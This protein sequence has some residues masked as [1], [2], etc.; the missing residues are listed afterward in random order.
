MWNLSWRGSFLAVSLVIFLTT[1]AFAQSE[2]S[3]VASMTC[4]TT[5]FQCK[6]DHKCIPQRWVCDGASDC[7]DESDENDETCKSVHCG[8]D[9]FQCPNNNCISSVWRCDGEPDCENGEDEVGC[10][11]TCNATTEFTC[12]DGQ[13]ISAQWKCDSHKDCSDGSDEEGCTE[14]KCGEF[15]F[16]CNNG[17][18]IQDT[19]VCDGDD[20]CH[21]MSDEQQGCIDKED[22]CRK[23]EFQC[24]TL[25]RMCIHITW[26]CDGDYDCEDQSDEKH[27]PPKTCENNTFDCLGDGTKCIPYSQVCDSRNDCGDFQDETNPDGASCPEE[28]PCNKA[29]NGGCSQLCNLAPTGVVC[30]CHPGFELRNGSHFDCD[31]IDECSI[32]GTCSQHCR[33]MKGSYKC[34]CIK[35]Y[36]LVNEHHCKALEG[37]PELFLADR[38][39]LRRYQ[40]ETKSY[41]LLVGKKDNTTVKGAIAIDFHY[42]Q[43]LLYWTDVNEEQIM[44]IDLTTEKIEMVVSE[45]VKTPDGLAVDW[46]HHHLY[47]TDTGMNHIEVATLDGSKRKVLISDDLDEPRAIA[48]DPHNAYIYWTDWGQMPKIEKCGM[49][50]K[51]RKVI[52][53]TDITWPNGL[54]IDYVDQ[55]LYWIDAK[56]HQ[57]GSSDLEGNNRK[58]ILRGHQYL[59]HP[60]AITVFEDYLYWSDWPSESV[61]RFNKF[62][63]GEVE[64]IAQGLNYPMDIHIYH[65]Y[66]QQDYKNRCGNNNGGCEQ[67]CL[68]DPTSEGFT[69]EC[70]TNFYVNPSDNT[71]CLA[72]QAPITTA[73]PTTQAPKTQAPTTAPAK[74]VTSAVPKAP[75]PNTTPKE[76][77]TTAKPVSST[78]VSAN[79]TEEM[80]ISKEHE[81]GIGHVAIIAI[82]VVFIIFAII[83]GV[84]VFVY[85]RYR[86]K[87]IKSMNFDNPV[88][89]KTTTDDQLIMEKSGSRQNLPASYQ[90]LTQPENEVV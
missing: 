27:S 54:T 80:P 7:H 86:R 22:K 78:E 4:S 19:W 25:D 37:Q 70:Q 47:W 43:N 24:K 72:G 64:T 34:S 46:V 11:N 73:A 48:L 28:N 5:D 18:C 30:S 85:R 26:K 10:V 44:R 62:Q 1:L 23:S 17:D 15:E 61:R 36:E 81:E 71:K 9:E 67:F 82:V 87:N 76:S 35:G 63:H 14:T 89:R 16:Q 50:G 20:D 49:N 68:P 90:P 57:I 66:R 45:N 32:P 88:Y 31:D 42:D 33:N 60:F 58:I 3:A 74:P 51:Q 29:D 79:A 55:R 12:H 84:G 75:S 2:E 65:K 59:G 83:I 77:V 13:C 53:S 56:T 38:T 6:T 52:V 21:D 8:A 40:L 69:C 39:D 41:T